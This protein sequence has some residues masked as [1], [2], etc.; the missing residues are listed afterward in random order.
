MPRY[1][2]LNHGPVLG[3]P[4]IFLFFLLFLFL[5]FSSYSPPLLAH[6]PTSLPSNLFPFRSLSGVLA[7]S[8]FSFC[9]SPRSVFFFFFISLLLPLYL[10][11]F[12]FCFP[13][14]YS[15]ISQPQFIWGRGRFR[16]ALAV[17]S[18]RGL[19]LAGQHGPY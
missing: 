7:S 3:P 5:A 19:P 10:S 13:S 18:G 4:F 17:K 2:T 15:C 16:F 14:L 11:L 9:L 6:T 8:V 1:H 12:L